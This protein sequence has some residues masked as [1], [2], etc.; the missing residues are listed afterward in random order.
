MIPIIDGLTVLKKLRSNSYIPVIILSAKDAD[1]DKIIGLGLGA[2]DYVTKP[3]NRYF[4]S[5][6]KGANYEEIVIWK[7]INSIIKRYSNMES[8]I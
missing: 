1:T 7:S 6:N 3:F 5:K 4:T 2:D 8:F